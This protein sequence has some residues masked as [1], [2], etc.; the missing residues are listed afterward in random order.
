[1]KQAAMQTVVQGVVLF[2]LMFSLASMSDAD[3]LSSR[4]ES[5]FNA[6]SDY[7]FLAYESI[8]Q[9]HADEYGSMRYLVMDFDITLASNDIQGDIHSICSVVLNDRELIRDLSRSGYDMVS[10]S[11]D[12]QSQYDCL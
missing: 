7:R 4:I 3:E 9:A 12:R 10:V 1:M 11:F 6:Q 5:H 8:D 2:L